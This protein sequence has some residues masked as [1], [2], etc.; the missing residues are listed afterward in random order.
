MYFTNCKNANESKAEY[1]RLAM[2]YHP[3]RGGDLETMKVINVEYHDHLRGFD[4]QSFRGFDGKDHTYRYTYET[5]QEI[6]DKI[7]ELFKIKM[8][9]VSIELIGTWLWVHGETRPYR[10]QLKEL[11]LKWH[12]KRLKW[13]FH[14]KTSFRRKYS[15]T[16]FDQMRMMYGSENCEQEKQPDRKEQ[17]KFEYMGGIKV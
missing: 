9:N 1:R 5:E 7:T 17:F 2:Q 6:L 8:V 15:G 14:T 16:S 10:E 4:G 12:S 11:S 13:F 3:D